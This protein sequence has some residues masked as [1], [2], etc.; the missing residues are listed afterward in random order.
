M[1]ARRDLVRREANPRKDA[2]EAVL[3]SVTTLADSSPEQ[4]AENTCRSSQ[5][6]FLTVHK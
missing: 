6:L 3:D 5:Q 1:V 4:R 2:P